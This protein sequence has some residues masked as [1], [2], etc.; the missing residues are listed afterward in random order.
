MGVG[1]P[2]VVKAIDDL[3]GAQSLSVP[4]VSCV[5]EFGENSGEAI[6]GVEFLIALG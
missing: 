4:E 2:E 1:L 3:E 6:T 5:D